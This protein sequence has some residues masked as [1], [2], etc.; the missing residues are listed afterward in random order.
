MC[1]DFS[2]SVESYL[3]EK[4]TTDLLDPLVSFDHDKIKTAFE[5]EKIEY[6]T[7]IACVWVLYMVKR[8]YTLSYSFG[9]YKVWGILNKVE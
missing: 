2:F 1:L 3:I 7:V 6:R 5:M 9:L 4:R 8:G